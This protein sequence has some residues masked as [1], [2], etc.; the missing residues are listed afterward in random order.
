MST[1]HGEIKMELLLA[2]VVFGI[3]GAITLYGYSTS[4]QASRDIERRGASREDRPMAGVSA[5]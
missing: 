4:R 2:F 3:L 5:E 1:S